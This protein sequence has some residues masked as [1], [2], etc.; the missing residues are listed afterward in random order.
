MP[1][2]IGIALVY[3]CIDDEPVMVSIAA[4]SAVALI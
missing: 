1:V 2:I 3:C 4:R